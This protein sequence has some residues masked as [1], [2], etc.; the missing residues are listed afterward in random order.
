MCVGTDVCACVVPEGVQGPDRGRAA[1]AG[2]RGVSAVHRLAEAAEEARVYE[3]TARQV[4][5]MK[6]RAAGVR[7][8]R[9]G[10]VG[11][12]GGVGW[13][14]EGGYR[15]VVTTQAQY[16]GFGVTPL[17]VLYFTACH[18]TADT[19]PVWRQG[20]PPRFGACTHCTRRS[21]RCESA[22]P[23]RHTGGT[24]LRTRGTEYPC[25]EAHTHDVCA[26]KIRT[27]VPVHGCDGARHISP[28]LP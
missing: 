5:Q 21:V 24:W 9:S 7:R 15:T 1:V 10:P 2:N 20:H 12:R 8:S 14:V 26:R 3:Q 19:P 23:W 25:H 16:R 13:E 6:A 27:K 18:G 28:T 4:P 17:G 22:H 11:C